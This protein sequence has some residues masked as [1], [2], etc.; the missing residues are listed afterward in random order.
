MESRKI[1]IV[2]TGNN[3]RKE[4]MSSATTLKELKRDL[5]N[6]NINYAGMSFYEAIS[7]TELVS[8][9]AILPSNL[10]WKGKITNDLI[11]TLSK[12]EKHIK[13]GMNTMNRTEIYNQIK[14]RGLSEE[15]KKK[16]GK[17]FTQCSTESLV[18]F[19]TKHE[20]KLSKNSSVKAKSTKCKSV[21]GDKHKQI[22]DICLKF[23]NELGHLLNKNTCAK[24]ELYI[25]SQDDIN[26][27]LE[28]I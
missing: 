24:K 14:S 1:V 2:S 3:F 5:S 16:F 25:I 26:E 23:V 19:I 28:S 9:D 18:E 11:F 21:E 8:D 4:F 6:N 27:V 12:T 10:P 17:N 22:V 20:D 13:S 7:K 15:I